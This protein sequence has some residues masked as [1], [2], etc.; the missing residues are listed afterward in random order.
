MLSV[1]VVVPKTP[2]KSC[3][4]TSTVRPS[5]ILVR[6]QI[7]NALAGAMKNRVGSWLGYLCA[8]TPARAARRVHDV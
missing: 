6:A 2:Q 4:T 7:A 1:K 8:Q 5:D 3:T